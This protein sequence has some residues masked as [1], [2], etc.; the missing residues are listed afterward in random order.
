MD[1]TYSAKAKQPNKL[2]VKSQQFVLLSKSELFPKNIDSIVQLFVIISL[3]R[4]SQN[5]DYLAYLC[6]SQWER[7]FLNY[8]S[9]QKK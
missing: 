9:H 1:V 2:F 4:N 7:I 6:A 8:A 3:I 5:I